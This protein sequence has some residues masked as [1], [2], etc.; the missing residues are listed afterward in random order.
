VRDLLLNRLV[1]SRGEGRLL[2]YDSLVWEG[3]ESFTMQMIIR[4]SVPC[5]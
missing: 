5:T 4:L 1:P 3:A 2:G